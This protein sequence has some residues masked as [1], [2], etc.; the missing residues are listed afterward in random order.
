MCAQFDGSQLYFDGGVLLLRGTE[1]GLGLAAVLASCMKDQREPSS[2][3]FSLVDTIRVCMFAIPC[4]YE[5]YDGLDLII[6]TS[7][8]SAMCLVIGSTNGSESMP[9]IKW[10]GF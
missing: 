8:S 10:A 5:D 2:T 1:R 3:T 7:S 9:G 6:L 4:G